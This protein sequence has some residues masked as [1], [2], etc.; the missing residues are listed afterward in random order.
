MCLS[1]FSSHFIRN[2][3][4]LA[5]VALEAILGLCY[6]LTSTLVG[7]HP[8]AYLTAA[9]VAALCVCTNL[10]TPVFHGSALIQV[11][12]KNQKYKYLSLI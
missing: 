10:L 5:F 8:V 6:I 12:H 9:V 11:Y 7:L 1:R 3:H 4:S 2:L